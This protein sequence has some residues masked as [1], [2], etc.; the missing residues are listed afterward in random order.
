[1]VAIRSFVF[2]PAA[3]VGGVVMAVVVVGPGCV[4]V[5]PAINTPPTRRR[6]SRIPSDIPEKR[7]MHINPLWLKIRHYL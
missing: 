6:I 7:F 5:H 1:V 4:V 2:S 3:V